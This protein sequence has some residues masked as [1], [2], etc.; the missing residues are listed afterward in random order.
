MNEILSVGAREDEVEIRPILWKINPLDRIMVQE[1]LISGG[2][3]GSWKYVGADVMENCILCVLKITAVGLK[4]NIM[5]LIKAY[6]S[7]EN[8][9]S[10][11][12]VKAARRYYILLI[13]LPKVLVIDI[14][15]FTVDY[16]IL[17][18]GRLEKEHV[19]SLESGVICLYGRIP[20]LIIDISGFTVDYM[21]LYAKNTALHLMKKILITSF[22]EKIQD[23][24]RNLKNESGR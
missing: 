6:D 3:F 15:G 21:I 13:E 10:D 17:R 5:N 18:Y 2:R 4:Q 11:Y 8:D 16:M 20:V 1:L 23:I 19:D 22:L 7:L 12:C 14:G 9:E 24:C